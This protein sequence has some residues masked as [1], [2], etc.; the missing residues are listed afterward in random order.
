MTIIAI[1]SM[2]K[3]KISRALNS[4]LFYKFILHGGNSTVVVCWSPKPEMRVRF[5]L[6]LQSVKVVR[7]NYSYE[8]CLN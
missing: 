6:P 4:Y 8:C 2:D 5:L 7:K 1:V 3:L